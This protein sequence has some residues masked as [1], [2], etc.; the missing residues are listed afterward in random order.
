MKYK[1]QNNQP[2]KLEK[3]EQNWSTQLT[4]P[5]FKIYCKVFGTTILS[6]RHNDR[7]TYQSIKPRAQD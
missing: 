6:H 3:Q 5:D 4:H 2:K 7:Q 1:K